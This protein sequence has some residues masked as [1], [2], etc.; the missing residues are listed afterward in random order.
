MGGRRE[1][2]GRTTHLC[3]SAPVPE[4][5]LFFSRPREP[6]LLNGPRNSIS[7]VSKVSDPVHT[8]AL[9]FLASFK[10]HGINR[11]KGEQAI[12]KIN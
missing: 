11:G 2:P 5:D 12:H 7:L 6:F 10:S 9:A 3:S 1:G 8:L 4:M